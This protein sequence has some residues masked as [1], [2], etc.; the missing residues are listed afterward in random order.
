MNS[1]KEILSVPEVAKY[2]GISRNQAYILCRSKNFPVLRIGKKLIKISLLEL[3]KWV[4][5]NS[6]RNGG[7]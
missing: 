1:Q 5:D 4:I 7:N 2:L 3:Q 6:Y